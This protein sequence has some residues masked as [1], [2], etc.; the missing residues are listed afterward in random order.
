MVLLQRTCVENTVRKLSRKENV[1]GTASSKEGVT[2][3]LLE[4]ETAPRNW[5]PWRRHN[6]KQWFL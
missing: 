6:Y 3:S 2:D 1:P 5:F 4:D